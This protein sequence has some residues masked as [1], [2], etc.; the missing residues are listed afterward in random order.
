VPDRSL[1]RVPFAALWN[2]EE[3]TYLVERHPVTIAPSAAA[4]LALRARAAHPGTGAPSSVL[5]VGASHPDKPPLPR[6]AGEAE[7]VAG[8]YPRSRVL[9][10]PDA[11]LAAF[12]ESVHRA[13]VIHFAGHGEDDV[14]ALTRSRLFFTPADAEDPGVLHGGDLVDRS[15]DGTRLA[16]LAA[17]RTAT[18]GDKGRETVSG[19]AAAFL[20]AGVP[21]VVA[22]L[23]PVDDAATREVMIELHRNLRRGF[24]P[25]QALQQAQ[26]EAIQADR[27]PRD[28][29]GMTV[30]GSN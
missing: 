30:V 2:P 15:F 16:V 3:E 27:H 8:L 13:E 19:L 11:T 14:R 24:S 25:A 7:G 29:A 4:Y 21:T 22:S 17:C 23:W 9:T 20:A 18:W 12:F 1:A 6:V 28:W 5:A 26:I 10:G